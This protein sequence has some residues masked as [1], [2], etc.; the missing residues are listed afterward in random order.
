MVIRGVI[1]AIVKK[2]LRLSHLYF[3]HHRDQTPNPEYTKL[4]TKFTA[5]FDLIRIQNVFSFEN[6]EKNPIYFIQ[7]GHLYDL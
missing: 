2:N 6:M 7:K 5:Y 4:F 3:V 1:L